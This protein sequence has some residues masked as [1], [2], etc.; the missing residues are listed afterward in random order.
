MT[1]LDEQLA[2]HLD[3][4]T[5]IQRRETQKWARSISEHSREGRTSTTTGEGNGKKVYSIEDAIELGGGFGRFQW[6]MCFITFGSY[7]RHGISYYPLPY[8]E[9]LPEFDCK[10]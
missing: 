5:E 4:T 1:D 8:M 6:I 3:E 2:E 7:I 10:D 9:L